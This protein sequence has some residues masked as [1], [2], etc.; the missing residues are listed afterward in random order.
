L[1]A[2]KL[3]AGLRRNNLKSHTARNERGLAGKT[4]A[5]TYFSIGGSTQAK[6]GNLTLLHLLRAP[7]CATA[8]ILLPLITLRH[9]YLKRTF[10]VHK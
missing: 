2:E 5:G 9:N 3:A 4:I 7:R 8:I 10:M 6:Y 1:L